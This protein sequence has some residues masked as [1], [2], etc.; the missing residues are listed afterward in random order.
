MKSN[1]FNFTEEC[2]RLRVPFWQCPTVLF[3]IMGIVV[4]GA[5]LLSYFSA[6]RY[7]FEPEVQA[8]LA[9][10]VAAV[11][12]I[13][14]DIVVRSFAKV[15]ETSYLKSQFLNILSHQLLTP[16]SS[17]KWAIN[18]LTTDNIKLTEKEREEFFNIVRQSNDNMINIVN[19]LLDVSRLDVGKIKLI[20]EKV[21]PVFLLSQVVADKRRDASVKGIN[22]NIDAEEHL[23]EV[24]TDIARTKVVLSNL[25]DNAI[26]FSKENSDIV[27]SLYRDGSKVVFS[28]EDFGAGMSKEKKKKIYKKLFKG[29][30][31]FKYQ[32]KSFG[33]GLFTSK[34]IVDALGDELRFESEE[35]VGSRFWFSLPI[36][37][38]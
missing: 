1:K 21:S 13:V 22:L 18:L 12:F 30:N 23:P 19:S 20:L 3:V 5:I 31:I 35:G 34:F 4:I 16:L 10:F 38:N 14:G 6:R 27:I 11:T 7:G 15:A 37:K 32:T 24:Q 29:E 25:I 26:K 33:L 36:Y 8:L 2:S 17:L 9:L 28:I